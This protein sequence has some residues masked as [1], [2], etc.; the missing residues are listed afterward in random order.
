MER[1]RIELISANRYANAKTCVAVFRRAVV[2][3]ETLDMRFP[4]EN[5]YRF[6]YHLRFCPLPLAPLAGPAKSWPARYDF[7]LLVL[8]WDLPDDI[9]LLFWCDWIS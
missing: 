6:N 9:D 7:S 1:Q 2:M 3:C 8:F 4:H 5:D